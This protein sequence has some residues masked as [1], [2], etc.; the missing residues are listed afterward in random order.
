MTTD[1]AVQA[2][3]ELA[4]LTPGDILGPLRTGLE[5][6]DLAAALGEKMCR[7]PFAPKAFRGNADATAAAI[8]AGMELGMMPGQALRSF[9]VVEGAAGLTS[10]AMRALITRAGHHIELRERSAEKVTLAGRRRGETVWTE[11]TWTIQDAQRAGLAGKQVWRAYPA[12]ML[13]ARCTTTLA[14]VKFTDVIAGIPCVEELADLDPIDITASVRV[15]EPTGERPTTAAIL[16]AAESAERVAQSAEIDAEYARGNLS[17]AAAESA[18]VD[19]RSARDRADRMVERAVLPITEARWGAINA[20]FRDLGV[21][22]QGQKAD[23][24]KVVAHI[25]G[26]Q[27]ARGSELT[28]DEGRLV[29]NTLMAE[30]AH[31]LVADILGAPA[32]VAPEQEPAQDAASAVLDTDDYDP[33]SDA[34]WPMDGA[35][36]A[37]EGGQP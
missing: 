20:T 37:A 25:V 30:E 35:E 12:S 9:D 26:H 3:A 23:R 11:I 34:E 31:Q 29:H 15:S 6:M 19:A 5:A 13:L 8:L 28:A 16:A 18:E 22:G 7:S 33:T 27:V 24:L 14:K 21:N 10:H 32:R 17:P 4:T 2:H 36:A 1:L